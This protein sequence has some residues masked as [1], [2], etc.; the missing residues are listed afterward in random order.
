MRG[1]AGGDL[2]PHYSWDSYGE[3][4][5]KKPIK[6]RDAV[7]QKDQSGEPPQGA[8]IHNKPREIEH[9]TKVKDKRTQDVPKM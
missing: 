7:V 2:F 6:S 5:N 3:N 8:G 9:L 1:S 4:T